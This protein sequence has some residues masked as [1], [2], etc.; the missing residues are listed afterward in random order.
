M[1]GEGT[2]TGFAEASPNAVMKGRRASGKE[3]KVSGAGMQRKLS[4]CLG[5]LQDSGVRAS[6][7]SPD[8]LPTNEPTDPQ[9]AYQL[10]QQA[11]KEEKAVSTKEQLENATGDG[12][13]DVSR[14]WRPLRGCWAT[15]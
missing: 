13:K 6:D 8:T 15:C 2:V 1:Q 11:E 10:W 4:R 3:N 5:C 9:L 12:D 14:G 7:I